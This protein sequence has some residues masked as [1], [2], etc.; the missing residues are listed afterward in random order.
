LLSQAPAP[1]LLAAADQEKDLCVKNQPRLRFLTEIALFQT[2]LP[3]QALQLS[4][5]ASLT[6]LT[7]SAQRRVVERALQYWHLVQAMYWLQ[8]GHCPWTM[9]MSHQPILAR[10]Q[11]LL[12]TKILS[13]QLAVSPSTSAS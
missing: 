4:A 2:A 10:L 3:A 7:S 9:M 12:H 5:P 8:W 6:L 1:R 13:H 11:T